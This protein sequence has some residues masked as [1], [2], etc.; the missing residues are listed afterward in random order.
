MRGEKTNENAGGL[1]D[2]APTTLRNGESDQKH[3][4]RDQTICH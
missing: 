1:G 2:T 3:V 4:W